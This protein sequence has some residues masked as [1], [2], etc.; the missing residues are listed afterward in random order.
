MCDEIIVH[1]GDLAVSKQPS[2]VLT[3]MGLGS[4]ISICSYDPIARIGG[5]AHVLLPKSLSN[6]DTL[7][8]KSAEIAVPNLIKAMVRSGADIRR[9]K[10]ATAGGA[11]LF[12]SAPSTMNIGRRNIQAVNSMLSSLG[13]GIV[14]SDTGGTKGRTVKLYIG[15][16][17]FTV[18]CIGETEKVLADFS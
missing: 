12:K 17:T 10:V 4:C 3:I 15:T 8:A 2:A 16:G 1:M 13:I 11:Q 7:A 6:P 9:I 18:R 14:A 5:I